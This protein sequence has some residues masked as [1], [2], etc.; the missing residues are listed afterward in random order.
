MDVA[1][2]LSVALQ[3]Y[4]KHCHLKA[5]LLVF[6]FRAF[7]PHTLSQRM[8]NLQGLWGRH[9]A[10]TGAAPRRAAPSVWPVS[11]GFP[12]ALCGAQFVCWKSGLLA[13][14]N[15]KA[16]FRCHERS[17]LLWRLEESLKGTSE[18]IC[19]HSVLFIYAMT[20]SSNV[21]ISTFVNII[22]CN[23]IPSQPLHVQ[24]NARSPLGGKSPFFWF[25]RRALRRITVF[26]HWHWCFPAPQKSLTRL[27]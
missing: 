14:P 10:G 3:K 13:F 24:A 22:P 7:P 16:T 27:C 21:N 19:S 2:L 11:Q 23:H 6:W 8:I 26:A 1:A 25:W 20:S 12:G 5:T 17:G 9:Q 18:H 15:F 4:A